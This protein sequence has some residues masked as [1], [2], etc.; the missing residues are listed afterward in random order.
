[1]HPIRSATASERS[2]HG[3]PRWRTGEPDDVGVPLF[4]S[5]TMVAVFAALPMVCGLLYNA[6]DSADLSWLYVAKPLA[7]AVGYVAII[8]VPV[9]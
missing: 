9:L 3:V 6:E 1:V 2:P 8:F 5:T 7:L 4:L